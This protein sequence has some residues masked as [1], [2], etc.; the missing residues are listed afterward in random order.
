LREALTQYSE[1]E[2]ADTDNERIGSQFIRF[3]ADFHASFDQSD[4]IDDLETA[5]ALSRE[6]LALLP[7]YHPN[8]LAG[9]INLANAVVIERFNRLG[10]QE[11]LDEANSVHRI[12]S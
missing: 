7:V 4:K 11:D 10:G 2:V 9:S 8:H 6:C 3:A 5:I 1:L 12:R